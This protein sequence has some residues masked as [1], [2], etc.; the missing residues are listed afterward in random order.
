M[1]PPH[2]GRQLPSVTSDI[3]SCP[4]YC[5]VILWASGAPVCASE[6]CPE[7]DALDPRW[8][9]EPSYVSWKRIQYS[10]APRRQGLPFFCHLGVCPRISPYAWVPTAVSLRRG[11]C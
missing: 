3:I 9:S 11:H 6:R 5:V 10:S 2:L 7:N 1:A 4:K 8:P